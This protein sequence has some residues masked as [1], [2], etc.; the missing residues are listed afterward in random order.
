MPV[1]ALAIFGEGVVDGL[2]DAA[3]VDYDGTFFYFV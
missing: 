3:G 1:A 2:F